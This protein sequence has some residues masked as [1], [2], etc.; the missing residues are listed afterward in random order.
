MQRQTTATEHFSAQ[1]RRRQQEVH[2]S[3]VI[4]ENN[5]SAANHTITGITGLSRGLEANHM[6]GAKYRTSTGG[7]VQPVWRDNPQ[8]D[9]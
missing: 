3:G 5:Q 1:Y 8:S 2:K 7:D 6:S 4:G 9:G